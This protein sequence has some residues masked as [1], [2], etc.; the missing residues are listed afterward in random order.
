MTLPIFDPDVTRRDDGPYCAAVP[1]IA[2]WGLDVLPFVGISRGDVPL[3]YSG[4]FW[5]C[6]GP[7]KKE[8]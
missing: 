7:R 8:T 6:C 2:N 3:F 4:S 5:D 1:K